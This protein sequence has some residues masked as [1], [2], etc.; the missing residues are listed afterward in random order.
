MMRGSVLV[1]VLGML[2]IASLMITFIIERA[3]RDIAYRGL[4]DNRPDLQRE[5]YSAMMAGMAVLEEIKLFDGKLYGPQQG[6]ARALSEADY[7]PSQGYDVSINI[8]DESGK[9]PINEA[10]AQPLRA[11]LIALEIS[12]FDIDLMLDTLFDW[13]DED[14]QERPNGAE[15]ATYDRQS[16]VYRPAN[17]PLAT[18]DDLRLIEHW[19]EAFFDEDGQ[20]NEIFRK[21]SRC[22]SLYNEGKINVHTAPPF[23]LEALAYTDGTPIDSLLE[24]LVGP[25]GE[26]DTG[27]ETPIADAGIN[28]LPE[29]EAF[30][31]MTT[32]VATIAQ[33]QVTVSRGD[34]RSSLVA[35]LD[36]SQTDA[37]PGIE[38]SQIPLPFK[39]LSIR[40]NQRF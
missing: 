10:S 31:A 35:L 22:V 17:A 1:A 13:I 28:P 9:L 37:L 20:P 21:F 23:L 8:V 39:V 38:G 26:A 32:D 36:L 29:S 4:H 25:D 24:Y 40:E 12:E 34:V 14:D 33:M 7:R 19:D 2:F 6:W 5:A 11:L 30:R 3:I 16:P 18:L 15:D 27:D